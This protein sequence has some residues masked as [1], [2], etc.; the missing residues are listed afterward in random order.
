MNKSACLL[1]LS[2]VVYLLNSNMCRKK[3]NVCENEEKEKLLLAH[4]TLA[5]FALSS[6]LLNRVSIFAF[7]LIFL[8][9]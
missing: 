5:P 3:V 2:S 6:F 8:F 1:S 7:C 9:R 4:R